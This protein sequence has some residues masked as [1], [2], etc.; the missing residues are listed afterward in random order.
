MNIYQESL[1]TLYN[2]EPIEILL[3]YIPYIKQY[4][5]FAGEIEIAK[6]SLLFKINIAVYKPDNN[7][8]K[9]IFYNYYFTPN[10][11]YIYDLLILVYDQPAKYYYQL[12]SNFQELKNNIKNDDSSNDLN[13]QI[14]ID[15]KNINEIND[16]Q[17]KDKIIEKEILDNKIHSNKEHNLV[18]KIYKLIKSY[19][20]LNLNN[21]NINLKSILKILLLK[22]YI[23]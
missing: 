7:N 2:D 13:S 9:F 23:K 16:L 10:T 21:Y 20:N 6:S 5:N 19:G 12:I 14:N 18:R 17:N 3:D 1:Y 11:E 15:N 8:K 22:N 4:W